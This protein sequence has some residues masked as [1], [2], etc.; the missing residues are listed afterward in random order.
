MNYTSIRDADS[1]RVCLVDLGI[2]LHDRLVHYRVTGEI[3][4][5][6]MQQLQYLQEIKLE[7]SAEDDDTLEQARWMVDRYNDDLNMA[8]DV[9]AKSWTEWHPYLTIFCRRQTNSLS[10]ST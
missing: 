8:W 2:E 6:W 9:M 4:E 3:K 5:S 7:T 1:A 10:R